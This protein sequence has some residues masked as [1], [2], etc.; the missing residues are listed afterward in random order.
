MTFQAGLGRLLAFAQ[1]AVNSGV[2]VTAARDALRE[3]GLRFS[4]AAY[5]AAH[6]IATRIAT[7]RRLEAD[8]RLDFRPHAERIVRGPW[9]FGER[10]GQVVKLELRD[11]ATGAVQ[12]WDITLTTDRLMTRGQAIDQAL[13]RVVP[14][15]EEYGQELVGALYDH[16]KGRT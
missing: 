13:D 15:L 8:Q 16:T 6:R 9:G 4:N 2:G 5:S 14:S 3:G 7:V 11:R 12:D 1:R 10:W